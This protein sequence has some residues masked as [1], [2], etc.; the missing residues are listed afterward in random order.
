MYCAALLILTA[1]FSPDGGNGAGDH[2]LQGARAFRESRFQEALVE[3]QV[4]RKLGAPDA[5]GYSGATLVN[6]GRPE[7]ALEAFA[8]APKGGDALL[9]YYRAVACYDAKLYH[10][11]DRLLAEVGGRT[12]PQIAGQAAR[13]REAIRVVLAAEPPRTAIDWYLVRGTELQRAGRS[14]LAVAH[15]QE[16]A[17]LADRRQD[18]YR[19]TEAEALRDRVAKVAPEGALR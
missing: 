3:F 9:D 4:A 15:C 10:C 5:A 1:F 6:L 18:R 14:A 8:A 13:L 7:E 2:L 11:A 17:D 16:A 12:G 19:K